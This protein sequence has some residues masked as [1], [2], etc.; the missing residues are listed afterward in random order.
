MMCMCRVM[1]CMF[2]GC[3]VC[4]Y[5]CMM[6]GMYEGYGLWGVV[7]GVYMCSVFMVLWGRCEWMR[8]FM[9]HMGVYG[10]MCG[11][12]WHAWVYGMCLCVSGVW[13]CVWYICGGST[14]VHTCH[15]SSSAYTADRGRGSVILSG[16]Y[17]L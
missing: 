11:V 15:L 3:L 17:M 13:E 12:V 9:W 16:F 7:Y 2:M 4:V 1:E 5:V 14:C 8:Y 6:S 10:Y